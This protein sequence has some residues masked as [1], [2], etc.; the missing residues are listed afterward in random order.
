[1]RVAIFASGN[2]TNFEE[3][4]KQFQNRQLS[5]EVTLL[6]CDHPDAHV[7]ERAHR[8]NVPAY[9]WTVKAAGNKEKYEQRILK[10]LQSQKIDLILLAG[11]LRVVGPTILDHYEGRIINLHPAWL[12]EY[13][14]LHSIERAYHDRVQ[15]T[16]VTVHFIDSGLDTGPIIM[17]ERVPIYPD[18]S[19]AELEKRVHT[20]EHR[21]Y[22]Q[23]VKQVLS[24]LTTKE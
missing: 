18:D 4:A 6:F 13:P 15:Q 7:I 17:Q 22:P 8:L 3:L 2:G 10:L 11:Y 14:G 23:A 20:V 21:L 16:G 19:L 12:P 9:S 24:Q 1:M 5:G